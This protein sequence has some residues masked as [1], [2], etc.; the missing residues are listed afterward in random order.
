MT[1]RI[2][3][4]VSLPSYSTTAR[5]FPENPIFPSDF[6]AFVF[7]APHAKWSGAPLRIAHLTDLHVHPDLPLEYYRQVVAAAEQAKPDIAVFTGDFITRL[8]AL[9]RLRQVL[10]LEQRLIVGVARV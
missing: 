2:S 9:P 10:R 1:N 5:R 8:D 6:V 7:L 4:A 3:S